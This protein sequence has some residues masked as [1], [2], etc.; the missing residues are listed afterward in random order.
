[1]EKQY[2]HGGEIYDKTIRLDYSIN[3]NP[4]RMPE[5]VKRAIVKGIEEDYRYPDHACGKLREAIAGAR[6]LLPE[7]VFCGNG[8][9]DVIYRYALAVKP[10]K[11]LLPAPTFSEYEKA[12]RL[13]GAE[14]LYYDLKEADGFEVREDFLRRMGECELAV[15]CNPNNP[16]GNLTGAELMKR[17]VR[18]AKENGIRL[19]IDECF[20]EFT[21]EE[22]KYSLI[23]FVGDYDGLFILKAFTKTYAMA[24]IR[25]GYGL[26]SEKKL[27]EGMAEAGAPWSVSSVAQRAGIAALKET[28]YL[29]RA[30]E[31]IEREREFLTLSLRQL[32]FRV[33]PSK[34]NYL[35]FR[36]GADLYE[37]LLGEEILIRQCGNYRGLGKEYYRICVGLHKENERLLHILADKKDKEDEG[38]KGSSVWQR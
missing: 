16:V 6:G 8:A 15:L 3:V 14:I 1:M 12:F 13:A 25:L 19:L 24:G 27:L 34:A 35:M 36:A 29:R 23:P 37:R 28:D 20:M 26:T 22:E 17:I 11:V 38:K 32:G 30:V 33:Y 2:A 31:M 7:W 21:G 9:A 5:G 4:L 18:K 10:S